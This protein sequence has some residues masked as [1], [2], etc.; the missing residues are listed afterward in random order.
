MKKTLCELNIRS[1]A[2]RMGKEMQ[3]SILDYTSVSFT[4]A[5]PTKESDIGK[6]TEGTFPST[7]AM[8]TESGESSKSEKLSDSEKRNRSNSTPTSSSPATKK[9]FL[10]EGQDSLS[11]IDSSYKAIMKMC[12]SVMSTL[13][14]M[15]DQLEKVVVAKKEAEEKV[16]F[17]E[18]RTLHLESQSTWQGHIIRHLMKSLDTQEQYSSRECLVLHGVPEKYHLDEA[19]MKAE[20]TDLEAVNVLNS[21]LKIGISEM[22][23]SRSHRLGKRFPNQKRPRPIIIKLVRHNLKSKLYSAKRMFKGTKFML[24]ER[25]TKRRATMYRYA[26]EKYGRNNT[27]TKDGEIFAKEGDRINNVTEYL[28]SIEEAII[29]Q[30]NNISSS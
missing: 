28:Y 18:E 3:S 15:K 7:T 10:F 13:G 2:Q 25:L 21:H 23:I 26:Q 1:C 6:S 5:S 14:E 11:D 29:E 20:D 12:E 17:L 8:P 9:V 30:M 4:A 16:A 27:W 19:A 24:T 22:D